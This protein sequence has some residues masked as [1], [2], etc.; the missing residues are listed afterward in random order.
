[1]NILI[2]GATGFVG[3]PLTHT[4]RKAGHT[5]FRGVR[6]PTHPNDLSIDYNADIAKETWLPRLKGITVVIN[7]VGV[8]RD[9]K[10]NRW[11]A[12]TQKH[13]QRSSLRALKRGW[14]A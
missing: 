6:N 8:L 12:C 3:R 1:M 14:R 7:A 2:C 11:R 9:G 4:L 5:V 10:K 13:P